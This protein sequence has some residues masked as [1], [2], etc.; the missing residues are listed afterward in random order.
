MDLKLGNVVLA[1][2]KEVGVVTS[3]RKTHC[4]VD[5][6]GRF[7][8]IYWLREIIELPYESL[9]EYV[10]ASLMSYPTGG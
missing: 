6:G 4:V 2:G 3:I 7:E 8:T 1:G 10:L 5:C 9:G